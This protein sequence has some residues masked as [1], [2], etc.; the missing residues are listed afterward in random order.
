MK[1]HWGGWPKLPTPGER[2]SGEHSF[3]AK[4]WDEVLEFN[5]W[6]KVPKE[7]WP[8]WQN[9]ND[10]DHF[11][12]IIADEG[13]FGQLV[14]FVGASVEPDFKTPIEWRVWTYKNFKKV[15]YMIPAS[16]KS[17]VIW[18]REPPKRK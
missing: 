16:E 11:I 8:T 9:M 18:Y 15:G 2:K 7:G 6:Q 13:E 4:H 3:D 1:K 17:K 12:G 10:G 14:W 5:G